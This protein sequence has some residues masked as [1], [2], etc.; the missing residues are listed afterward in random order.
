MHLTVVP[1]PNPHPKIS[2][3]PAT[4]GE[5]VFELGGIPFVVDP[6]DQ[7][8][9]REATLDHVTEEGFASF[10]MDGPFLP[11]MQGDPD[12]RSPPG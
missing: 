12:E 9:F 7:P 1:G 5:V 6:S 11:A 10:Q 2:F 8:F 3:R 4:R